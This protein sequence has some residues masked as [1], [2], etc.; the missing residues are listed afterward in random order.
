LDQ[1]HHIRIDSLLLAGSVVPK[2]SRL[3]ERTMSSEYSSVRSSCMASSGMH[4]I[5]NG[6][7]TQHPTSSLLKLGRQNEPVSRISH[8]IRTSAPFRHASRITMF[9]RRG[10]S[11]RPR[12]GLAC[13]LAD[14][15]CLRSKAEG[16]RVAYCVEREDAA[17]LLQQWDGTVRQM[18]PKIATAAYHTILNLSLCR[19][20]MA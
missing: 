12:H 4:G 18:Q 5:S 14:D 1:R 16:G 2:V 13:Y 20:E 8:C 15:A 17:L 7:H 11:G 19:D 10:P 6:S 9:S 3:N